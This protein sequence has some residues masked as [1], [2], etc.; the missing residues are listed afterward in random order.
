[1]TEGF[2]RYVDR[3]VREITS[4]KSK[5]RESRYW[6]PNGPSS[7]S[8]VRGIRPNNSN[9]TDSQKTKVG[10]SQQYVG[11]FW[12]GKGIRAKNKS[13]KSAEEAS[14]ARGVG[15]VL[16]RK[17]VNP[18]KVGSRINSKQGDMIIKHNLPDGSS[19]V[20]R[21]IRKKYDPIKMKFRKK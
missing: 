1:M 8:K 5:R 21:S 15:G 9:M 3:L 4:A 18:K 2:D 13:Q 14:I 20:G 10:G 19:R 17:G 12:K 16:K 11:D 6:N 7:G